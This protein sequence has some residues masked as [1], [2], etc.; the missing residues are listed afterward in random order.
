[1]SRMILKRIILV[2]ILI[3]N[4]QVEVKSMLMKCVDD[5]LDGKVNTEDGK[6]TI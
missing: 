3:N 4:L 6:G 2:N 5:K 1:M